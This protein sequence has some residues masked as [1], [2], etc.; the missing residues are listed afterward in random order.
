MKQQHVQIAHLSIIKYTVYVAL[1]LAAQL[2]NFCY[3]SNSG[4]SAQRA[5]GGGGDWA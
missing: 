4:A 3:F 1:I 2:N 5:A